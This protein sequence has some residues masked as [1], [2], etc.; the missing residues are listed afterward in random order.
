MCIYVNTAGSN[1]FWRCAV[2]SGNVRGV[3]VE[4]SSGL[5]YGGLVPFAVGG[6][7]G[8]I[9]LNPSTNAA[10][11]WPVFPGAPH[12]VAID[13]AGRVY[14]AASDSPDAIVRVDPA[15]NAVTRWPIIPGGLSTGFEE[16]AID[17]LNFDQ[18]GNLWL[19][20][21]AGNKVGRLN[22]VSNEMC[23]FTK[24]EVMGPQQIASSGYGSLLQSFFT[25]EGNPVDM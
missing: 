5:M 24:T 4:Q 20:M 15:T 25:A 12:Y 23:Q 16:L 7:G 3:K 6:T 11:V 1:K 21:S 8:V 10:K 19:A 18:D 14:T 9:Q 13:S 22:A 2:L 17:G